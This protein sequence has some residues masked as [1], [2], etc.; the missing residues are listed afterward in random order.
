ME[1][2]SDALLKSLKPKSK[3]YQVADGGGLYVEVL[4]TG[5]KSF[6]YGY[7]IYGKKEKVTIGSYPDMSLK[8]ARQR[9]REFRTLVE[10]HQSPARQS[11]LQKVIKREEYLG[12]NSFE[13]H[14]NTWLKQWRLGKSA[15]AAMQAEAWLK[16]NVF[17]YLGNV[18]INQIEEAD[19]VRLLDK[20]KERGAPQTA[21]RI[22][23]H[24]KGIFRRAKKR[25][26]IKHDPTISI[27]GSEVAPKSERD[28][29]L[30]PAELRRFLIALEEDAGG[31]PLHLG[32][33][34]ILLTLC[35]KDEIRLARWEQINFETAELVIP[36][37][38]TGRAHIVYLSRQAIELLRTL[39]TLSGDSSYVLPHR[40]R[41]GRP[42]GHMSLNHV[43]HR[44]R[45]AGGP[46]HDVPHFTVHDLR[47]T[48]STR[49]HE[50]NFLP[51]IVETALGHRI[52]GVR[53][54]YNRA[55]YEDQRR[56]M[57]QWWADWLDTLEAGRNL[58]LALFDRH[59]HAA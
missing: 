10:N 46:L 59:K 20:I 45:C 28:R 58:V 7:R 43:L 36:R 29:A 17:P 32:L 2:L 22:L 1:K 55:R 49:L 21:K 44:L 30:E 15:H 5:A 38:K 37:T 48:G 9:H 19:L 4:P 40:D 57:L 41:S 8:S 54:V 6:R 42:T 51:D 11:R 13:A 3:S 18:P 27:T 47:R 33:R 50:A 14:A 52:G 24:L 16:A 26:F 35:R 34:L 53:G 39:K 31:Q 23:S 56:E 12:T 25:G